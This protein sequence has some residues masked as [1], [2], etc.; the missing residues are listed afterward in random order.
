MYDHENIFAK[1]LRGEIPCKEVYHDDY[2][3]AFHDIEP[4]AP[5]HVLVLPK[6]EFISFDDFIQTATPVQVTGFFAAVQT[7]AATL[8]LHAGGYRIIS[9]HGANAN[10][11][12]AHFHMHILGGKP[13]GGLLADDIHER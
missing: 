10:Q 4:A 7:V 5:V 11:T 9:N 6:G 13:T 12:V 3:L 2:A 8:G 1:I